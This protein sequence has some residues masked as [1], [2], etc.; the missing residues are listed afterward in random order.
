VHDAPYEIHEEVIRG[1]KASW[2]LVWSHAK[3]LTVSYTVSVSKI[4]VPEDDRSNDLCF[5]FQLF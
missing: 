1:W 2:P 4:S 5:T 3:G